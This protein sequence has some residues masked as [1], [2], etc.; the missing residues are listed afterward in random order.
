MRLRGDLPR[1]AVAQ[2][3]RVRVGKR[4]HSD[5]YGGPPRIR[6][7]VGEGRGCCSR[8][9]RLAD[10]VSRSSLLKLRTFKAHPGRFPTG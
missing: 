4:I 3:C 9:P 7:T 1:Q 8:G 10:E 5:S 6:I 2:R